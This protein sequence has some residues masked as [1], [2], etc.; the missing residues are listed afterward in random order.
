MCERL[1]NNK[2]DADLSC[3]W[4]F[5]A[6]LAS[7]SEQDF[8]FLTVLLCVHSEWPTYSPWISSDILSMPIFLHFYFCSAHSS[9]ARRSSNPTQV[10]Q[11]HAFSVSCTR[12]SVQ[13]RRLPCEMVKRSKPWEIR[14][15]ICNWQFNHS[16]FITTFLV[17][18]SSRRSSSLSGARK[19]FSLQILVNVGLC[20]CN[21]N[22][23]ISVLSH[24]VAQPLLFAKHDSEELELRQC[25]I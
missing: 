3:H 11:L 7:D 12:K 14:R 2:F 23:T 4:F 22:W 21:F 17:S 25:S 13:I 6:P 8:F 20:S 9:L 18:L 24:L 16:S 5:F 1:F 10:N 19:D 15:R